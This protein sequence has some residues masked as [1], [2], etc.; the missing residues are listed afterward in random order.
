MA[1]I[2][3]C[4]ADGTRN[5]TEKVGLDNSIEQPLFTSIYLEL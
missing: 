2:P 3:A 5:D 4:T 1:A